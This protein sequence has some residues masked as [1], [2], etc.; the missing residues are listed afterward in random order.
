MIQ[1]DIITTNILMKLGFMRVGIRQCGVFIYKP[2]IRCANCQLY[3]HSKFNCKRKTIYA[4]CAMAHLTTSCPNNTN[5]DLMQCT[6]CIGREVHRPH[7]ADSSLCPAYID[8]LSYRNNFSNSYMNSTMNSYTN[9]YMNL[10]FF[11]SK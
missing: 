3:G 5:L 4:F 1:T 11:N 7:M 9:S 8:Q 2:I 6:N 10:S